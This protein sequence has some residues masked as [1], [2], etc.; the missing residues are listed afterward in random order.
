MFFYKSFFFFYSISPVIHTSASHCFQKNIYVILNYC[1]VISS[2]SLSTSFSD[3]GSIGDLHLSDSRS[4][5][6]TNPVLHEPDD[7]ESSLDSSRWPLASSWS[8]S[9][10]LQTSALSASAA[11]LQVWFWTPST[12]CQIL[13]RSQ[14]ASATS[15]SKSC[16]GLNS[17]PNSGPL[18]TWTLLNGPSPR[19]SSRTLF[20]QTGAPLPVEHRILNSWQRWQEQ[21][22]PVYKAVSKLKYI[23]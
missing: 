15:S 11:I 12:D 6:S 19:S 23:Q 7:S 20:C 2:T 10:S 17:V 22:L 21:D 18:A 13:H 16:W 1:R 9:S 5:D 8:S 3:S 4:S 14:L